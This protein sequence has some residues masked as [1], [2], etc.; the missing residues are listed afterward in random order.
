MNVNF[1]QLGD[2]HKKIVKS[3]NRALAYDHA[4]VTMKWLSDNWKTMD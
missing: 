2:A 3:L 1:K 4:I